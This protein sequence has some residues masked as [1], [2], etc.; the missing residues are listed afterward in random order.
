MHQQTNGQIV[1]YPYKR[2]PF[3][4]MNYYNMDDSQNNNPERKKLATGDYLLYTSIYIKFKWICRHKKQISGC[5]E[6][7]KG[8]PAMGHNGG[9]TALV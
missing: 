1:S 5:Q 9:D 8:Y 2:I 4:N 3:S 7:S 6:W